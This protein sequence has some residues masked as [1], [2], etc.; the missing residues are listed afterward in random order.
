MEPE[1]LVQHVLAMGAWAGHC[2]SQSLSIC[3]S[4]KEA[5]S[6]DLFSSWGCLKV[7]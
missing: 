3:L 4:K 5:V 7:F 6:A 1:D 2:T